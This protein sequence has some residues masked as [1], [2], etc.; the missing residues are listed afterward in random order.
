LEEEWP[1]R[2]FTIEACLRER[3]ARV[4]EGLEEEEG[5]RGALNSGERERERTVRCFQPKRKR[6][7]NSRL[8]LG[9]GREMENLR[10]I[11]TLNN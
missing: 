11:M 10:E 6:K 1:P 7:K 3:R 5:E 2:V 4:L 8:R 9:K